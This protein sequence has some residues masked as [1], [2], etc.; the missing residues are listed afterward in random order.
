MKSAICGLGEDSN[1][2]TGGGEL[3][4]ESYCGEP[5]TESEDVEASSSSSLRKYLKR[6]T[7]LEG[8]PV[9][10]EDAHGRISRQLSSPNIPKTGDRG[11]SW[12]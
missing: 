12:K 3:L 1:D 10:D 8:N 7:S 6:S 9:V 11:E 5:P 2:G 4:S